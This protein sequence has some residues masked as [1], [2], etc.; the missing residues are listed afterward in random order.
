[1]GLDPISLAGA[2]ISAGGTLF[3]GISANR[4]AKYQAQVAKNNAII[5]N[6]NANYAIQAGQVEAE[7]SSLRGASNLANIKA[8]QAASGID[9]HTGS[10]VDVQESQHMANQQDTALTLNNAALRSYG[11]RSQA[12]GYEAQAQLDKSAGTSALIGSGISATGGLL[13]SA[14]S[15]GFKWG[16]GNGGEQSVNDF[17]YE[18]GLF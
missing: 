5:A 4:A 16:G 8:G 11:Y 13:G 7:R 10:A 12:V 14:S 17:G 9:T 18:G 3:S 15:L 1:M 6:Q 2:A